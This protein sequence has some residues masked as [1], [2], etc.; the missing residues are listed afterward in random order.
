MRYSIHVRLSMNGSKNPRRLSLQQVWDKIVECTCLSPHMPFWKSHTHLHAHTY[1]R[2][3]PVTCINNREP[4]TVMWND[5]F[6]VQSETAKFRLLTVL[7]RMTWQN[8]FHLHLLSFVTGGWQKKTRVDMKKHE[9]DRTTVCK[10]M[11]ILKD[12]QAYI[13]IMLIINRQRK[14]IQSMTCRESEKPF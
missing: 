5:R 9:Q 12:R 7:Q 2:L 10:K 1:T 4:F 6:G 13:I 3:H 14:I 8:P 11:Q